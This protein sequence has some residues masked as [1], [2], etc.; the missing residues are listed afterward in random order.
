[1]ARC[2]FLPGSGASSARKNSPASTHSQPE[3]LAF[4][5]HI[6]RFQEELHSGCAPVLQS[7]DSFCG[8]RTYTT[9]NCQN[10][11]RDLNRFCPWPKSMAPEP[12][13][14][15]SHELRA[16]VRRYGPS[17]CKADG[18]RHSP[19]RRPGSACP[20]FPSALCRVV[21]LAS[22]TAGAPSRPTPY[23]LSVVA[24]PAS[25]CCARWAMA[26]RAP[27]LFIL[28]GRMGISPDCLSGVRRGR[29]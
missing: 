6:A 27:G 15:L 10:S 16:R 21:A 14:E 29:R 22:L 17:C 5:I 12:L 19:S 24:N 8:S 25:A 11:V 4:Y 2:P 7:A 26:L 20:G 13:A 1:M 23:V 28:H 3:I 9:G 18:Q